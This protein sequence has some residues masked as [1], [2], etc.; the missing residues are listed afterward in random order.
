MLEKRFGSL[1][2]TTHEWLLGK[3]MNRPSST[4]TAAGGWGFLAALVMGAVAI[5]WP[6]IYERVPPGFEAALA[7]GIGVVAGYCK[8][9]TVLGSNR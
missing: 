6:D 5:V 3:V 2:R 4:I 1:S 8:K 9:E 7:V